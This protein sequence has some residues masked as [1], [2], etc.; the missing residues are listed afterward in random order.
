MDDLKQALAEFQALQACLPPLPWRD[1][2]HHYSR[3]IRRDITTER[4]TI[5]HIPKYVTHYTPTSSMTQQEAE[6]T[7]KTIHAY[8]ATNQGLPARFTPDETTFV[9]DTGASITITNCKEDFTS[10][11][12]QV[13]PTRLKGIASG[14]DVKGIGEAEYAFKTDTGEMITVSF[15]RVLYVPDCT[16]RLLCPR[17]LAE[18]TGR[19]TDGFNSIRDVGILTCHGKAITVPYH[20]G[21]GLPIVTTATGIENFTKFCAKLS[22][23]N[24][25]PQLN[26]NPSC[27]AP[28]HF[29][30]NLTPQQCIKLLLHER[31]NHK[32]MKIINQWIRD[33]HFN[34]SPTVASTPDPIC[35]A[36]QYG[37]AHRKPHTRDISSIT[38][39]HST[40]GAGISVDLLEAGYPGRLPT[41]KG[42]PTTKRY[43]YCNLW[44]DNF[45]RYIYPTFHETKDV[46]EMIKSKQEFQ[47]FASRFNIK[48]RSIRAD[49]GAYASGMFKTACDLDQQ[50]LT[51]CAVG[52]HWQ[53]GIAERHIGIVTQTART[54]LLH[55]MAN[56]PGFINEE[57]WPFTI[58]HACTFHNA[59][60]RPDT[61]K[62]PHHLFTGNKA[63]WKM[64]DFRVFG[65]P[66]FVLDKKLQDGDSLSKWKARSWVGIYVGH[67]LVHSGNVPVVYNPRTS[68]ISPQFHVVHD[69]Q[70]TTVTG[71]SSEFTDQF[72]ER[73]YNNYK[74]F[75][76]DNFAATTDL[77]Y[78]ET[79]WSDPPSSKLDQRKSKKL[80]R[81]SQPQFDD[82]HLSKDCISKHPHSEPAVHSEPANASEQA[83]INELMNF[84]KSTI[85]PDLPIQ[86]TSESAHTSELAYKNVTINSTLTMEPNKDSLPLHASTVQVSDI[87]QKVKTNLIPTQC[88]ALFT[89]LKASLGIQADVFTAISASSPSTDNNPNTDDPVIDESPISLLTYATENL[90]ASNISTD[91]TTCNNKEDILT[92]SQMFKA[93]DSSEF[94]ACQ[95]DEIKGLQKFDVMDIEHISKLPA[96]AK[97]LSSIWSYRRKRLPNGVLLK[98]KSRICVNGKEQA[99]GRDYWETYAPVA[100][101]STIRLMIILSTLLNLKTRQVDY[102]QA[103]PQAALTEPV[104]MK[105]PQG[106]FV[107]EKGE[108]I[109]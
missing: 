85:K 18:S 14:L 30:Q 16:V 68:H 65:S 8:V 100:S 6:I 2:S 67:S 93:S 20:S 17:H 31:C 75:H 60:I 105:I 94:I 26:T 50:D 109:C 91:S 103:F 38:A 92:Q 86:Y 82:T 11:I 88:S 48:I 101:W 56:W 83:P 24:N 1:S 3:C 76:N 98:Y 77:H 29:K 7:R 90:A 55:A 43:K 28:I 89:Q 106:W 5:N 81:G 23:A 61:K 57:F 4:R 44:V 39:N 51:F 80:K 104:F 40:P 22:I 99:F 13:Q 52:G 9:I 25:A 47:A 79:Y 87:D 59:S 53:N 58:R 72:L 54:I 74:W 19:Q 102:T 34:I 62:S 37:K 63:P 95:R 41:T 21:T 66:T 49:N 97:L 45:S 10:A 69:D 12:Q 84:S 32:H 78:L 107:N 46:S 35:A 96:K 27:I 64:E 42:L 36:C 71:A 108:L 70:F 73:L 33:G 15:D